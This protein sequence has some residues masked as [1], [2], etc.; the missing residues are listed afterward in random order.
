MSIKLKLVAFS[1]AT[2]IALGASLAVYFF[3]TTRDQLR[4]SLELRARTI[5]RNLSYNSRY[6]LLTG[7]YVELGDLIAGVGSDP[8]V[9]YAEI[10]GVDGRVKVKDRTGNEEDT[11]ALESWTPPVVPPAGADPWILPPRGEPGGMHFEVAAPVLRSADDVGEP[12]GF[13]RVVF[14]SERTDSRI[15]HTLQQS[16]LITLGVVA[17]MIVL[18]YLVVRTT[19]RPL[20]DIT[21]RTVDIARGRFEER[22]QVDRADEI[23]TLGNAFNQMAS[24][25]ESSRKDLVEAKEYTENILKSMIDVL[26]VVDSGGVV[27]RANRAADGLLDRP[28]NEIVGRQ[29][30]ELFGELGGG[31]MMDAGLLRERIETGTLGEMNLSLVHRS[32]ELIPVSLSAAVLPH[33]ENEPE[34]YVCVAK[35]LRETRLLGELESAND[36]LRSTQEQLVQAGK[37]A[38]LGQMLSGIAHELNNP[39]T[40]IMG[41]S[42]LLIANPAPDRL[43]TGLKRIHKEA[44][45]AKRVVKDLLTF[46]REKKASVDRVDVKRVLLEALEIL[47]RE[48]ELE[49][50]ELVRVFDPEIPPTI[51]DSGQL[52]QVFVN[53]FQNA[54]HAMRSVEERRLTVTTQVEDGRIRVRVED[55]GPGVS[56]ED[57]DRIFEPFYTTKD[58]GQ[59]TGLGLSIT[60]SILEAHDGGLRYED[61]PDEGAVFVVDLPI[62]TRTEIEEGVGDEELGLDT[63][64]V[65]RDV[66]VVDDEESVSDVV[67]E[68]FSQQGNRIRVARNGREA[69]DLLERGDVFDLVLCDLKMPVMGG[70][71]LFLELK[72]RTHPALEH[73]VF[74]SGNVLDPAARSFLE[75]HRVPHLYKPFNLRELAQV[76]RTMAG[77]G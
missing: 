63:G 77:T 43:E 40:G 42:E 26:L 27:T 13:V 58:V 47:H 22:V 14:S 60:F 4:S 30:G 57:V 7:E 44:G 15:W 29:M 45:R 38:A 65:E 6:G 33:G 5:T 49:D 39:L 70:Q 10:R 35:D 73:F 55:S 74:I 76:A 2:L 67:E 52:V 46:A 23:G 1:V 20:E 69:L 24:A 50:V 28:R 37:M 71:E 8:D 61:S 18:S 21:A 48:V 62:D 68:L 64:F 36:E 51:G 11:R 53:L 41:F 66:L 19:I 25:I 75:E 34:D 31:V 3:G 32:G 72:Q 12:L 9:V 54:L 16:A 56:P 59:G 17:A